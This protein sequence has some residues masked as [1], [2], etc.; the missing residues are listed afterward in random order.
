M[1]ESPRER[2]NSESMRETGG[3]KERDGW[4]DGGR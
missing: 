3:E 4:R 2:E 1:R